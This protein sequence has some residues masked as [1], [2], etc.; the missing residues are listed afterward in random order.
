MAQL[1]MVNT[2]RDDILSLSDTV[3][4]NRDTG[5]TLIKKGSLLAAPQAITGAYVRV[6]AD[7]IP[8]YGAKY[9][10]IS[11]G[12]TANGSTGINLRLVGGP[13]VAGGFTTIQSTKEVAADDTTRSAANNVLPAGNIDQFYDFSLLRAPEFMEVQMMADVLGAAGSITRCDIYLIF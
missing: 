10:I 4:T 8:T 5:K 12:F 3:F 6:S 13:T 7:Q 2:T 1:A 9:M 11:L